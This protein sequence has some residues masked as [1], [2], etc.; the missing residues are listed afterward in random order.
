MDKHGSK[1]HLK[2]KLISLM[3]DLI[4]NKCPKLMIV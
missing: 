3:E 1:E 4:C 2:D